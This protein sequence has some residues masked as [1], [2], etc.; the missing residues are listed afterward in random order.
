MGHRLKAGKVK[1]IGFLSPLLAVAGLGLSNLVMAENCAEMPVSGKVYNLVNMGS[2]KYMDVQSASSANGA[3]IHQWSA[4]GLTNQQFTVNDMNN[5]YWSIRPVHS[6]KAVDLYGWS[7]EDGG[8]IKQWEYWGGQAQQWKLA[9][10][11]AGGIK[12][13]SAYTGKLISVANGDS[14]ADVFQKTDGSSNYQIWYFNPV[15]GGCGASSGGSSTSTSQLIG[16]ASVAGSGLSTTTGGGSAKPTEVSS[17]DQLAT[18][19]NSDSPGVIQVPNKALDCRTP[20]RV[21]SVCKF[22]CG[23][24]YEPAN[25]NKIFHWAVQ[26]NSYSERVQACQQI[27]SSFS[28]FK[29]GF[30][31]M[32]NVSLN[33][34]RIVVKSNKTLVGLGSESRVIGANFI[35]NGVNNVIIRNLAIENVNPSIIE[36]GDA[37]SMN[38]THHIWLDHLTTRLISDGH[39]DMYDS[40]NITLSWNRFDGDNGYSCGSRDQYVNLV[41]NSEATYH[42]NYFRHGN[43]R[44]PDVKG[45]GAKV[46]FFN[47]FWKDITRYSI[48]V[49]DFGQA[50]LEGNYFENS[51]KPHWNYKN[52]LI[53]ANIQSN[54]YTVLS[55]TDSFKDTGS[56]M[57]WSIPYA[58]DRVDATQARKAI[59]A[60]AGPK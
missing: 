29:F 18:A 15:N 30:K 37:I 1:F 43:G 59:I 5:G 39:V 16:F 24:I 52:G 12:V 19:L 47:N 50:K 26:G 22:T 60:G 51:V 13:A 2:G 53:D 9:K 11:D 42:H 7:K 36:A 33:E 6:N 27:E 14:G 3:N 54:V 17:C 55:G 10:S 23:N 38:N 32:E 58:Y 34:R 46:H 21:Q 35:L 57:T 8:T 45:Q 20:N 31:G 48:A 25:P 40:K 49:M 28:Y 41:V 56:R 4:N 44:N